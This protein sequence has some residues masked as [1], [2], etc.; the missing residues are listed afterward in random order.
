[1]NQEPYDRVRFQLPDSRYIE[2]YTVATEGFPSPLYTNITV[3]GNIAGGMTHRNGYTET[4]EPEIV[5][6][7]YH[8]SNHL[9]YNTS[10][11]LAQEYFMRELAMHLVRT[12]REVSVAFRY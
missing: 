8:S 2:I 9:D 3:I 10:I 4:I 6:R 1:M 7:T 12:R 5:R 11:R